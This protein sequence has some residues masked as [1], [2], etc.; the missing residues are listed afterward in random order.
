[1]IIHER[2]LHNA[3]RLLPAGWLVLAG[4]LGMGC[5]GGESPGQGTADPAS[6]QAPGSASPRHCPLAIDFSA[7]D[8][9][10]AIGR[11]TAAGNRPDD[12][13]IT[14]FSEN[15]VVAVWAQTMDQVD[16]QPL[17]VT[18]WLE[19]TFKDE[20]QV[21]DLQKVN[22]NRRTMAR[23][24]RY[25]FEHREEIEGLL[26]PFRTGTYDCRIRDAL[27][28][29]IDPARLPADLVLAFLPGK[30][31]I[32]SGGSTLL[33]DTGVLQAGGADQTLNQTVALAYRTFQLDDLENPN[34]QEGED[35]LAGTAT[36]IRNEGVA[37]YL[38]K[39]A[40]TYFARE[41]PTLGKVRIIPESIANTANMAVVYAD[42]ALPALF[43]DP[44]VMASR[45]ID[46]PRRFT[47]S[48]AFDKLGFAMA[49]TI[50]D[51]LGEDRLVAASRTVS[52]FWSAYQEAAA[53]NPL[54]APLP[55]ALGHPWYASLRPL[56]PEAFAGLKGLLD[57]RGL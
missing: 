54:P 22:S 56:D 50:A 41:H 48:G 34:A 40:E 23:T 46:M 14:A 49:A 10:A 36:L 13:L 27:D 38:E 35:A 8:A 26:A 47:A 53:L 11:E 45:A 39:R 28:R 1:M 16:V 24:Y 52:G 4:L 12:R 3:R 6:R 29:W 51:R 43:A 57:R 30:P 32:R 25:S 17:H 21:T 15:P 37:A 7:W 33:V 5:N 55:G 2:S 19:E 44:A 9:F 20:W 42:S 31:E 18:N